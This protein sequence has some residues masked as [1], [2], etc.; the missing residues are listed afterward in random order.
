MR[1][2]IISLAF[3]A[4]S[5]GAMG[6]SLH[7][8]QGCFGDQ[9]AKAPRLSVAVVPQLPAA[10]IHRAWAPVLDRVGRQVGHCYDLVLTKTIPDFEALF[11][12]GTPDF[13]FLNPY[14][15]VMAHARQGYKPL[16]AD[17]T[18]LTGILVVRQDSTVRSLK[19]LQGQSVAFPAPNAFA[20]SLLMRAILARE[21]V[22]I[23]A[24][25]VKT[26]N[27]VYRSVVQGGHAG[28]GGVNN[29]LEREP[30]ALKQ[31]LRVLYET[32][33]FSPHPFSVHPRVDAGLASAVQAALLSLS[34]S[35][36][37]RTLLNAIQMPRPR[38]VT[39]QADYKPLSDLRLETF[40]VQAKP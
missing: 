20:A 14:H 17:T 35:D 6:Q 2:C 5:V 33:G 39:Q 23:Q 22:A 1:A 10:D 30:D 11:L 8:A 26:H 37:G 25:Y 32:P 21:G 38:V 9:S 27:N 15:Q 34:A 12:K 7:Q 13:A 28:G 40:V 16:V 18:P 36:D 19:D 4:A 24:D 29:T 3:L 31:Q